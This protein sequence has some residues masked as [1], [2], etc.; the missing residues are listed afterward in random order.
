MATENCLR[1]KINDYS[2]VSEARR[3]AAMM[4]RELSFTEVESGNVSIIVTE[5]ASNLCKHAID[6]EI[7][8]HPLELAGSSG[9]EILSIDKGPGM[10]DPARSLK[11]G[12]STAGTLGTGLGAIVRGS[13]EFD[14]Y[15]IL[16]KGTVVM[17]RIWAKKHTDRLLSLPL[18]TGTICVPMRGEEDCGDGWAIDQTELKSRILVSDGLGHGP[19]A[20]MATRAAVEIFRKNRTLPPTTMIKTLHD[21][22]QSTRGAAVAV[23]E[24]DHLNRVVYY[25]GIGNIAGR[26]VTG[27]SVKNLSSHYGIIGQQFRKIQ[28]FSY[29]FSDDSI[30]IMNSDGLSTKLNFELCPDLVNHHPSIIAAVMFRDFARGNDDAV[31]MVARSVKG[32]E[33]N[34]EPSDC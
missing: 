18:V 9:I 14:I 6:G 15:S 3:H 25:S 33:V 22:L 28:E 19:Q 26:I 17:S 8:V 7:I 29:P 21:G 30:L 12:F 31:V 23:A 13:S 10:G 32:M 5:M 20:A 2:Q 27:E 4:S 11:D 16:G 1:I 24:V 34:H